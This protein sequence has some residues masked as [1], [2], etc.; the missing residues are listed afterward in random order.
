M[1][2]SL[3][4]INWILLI[5]I[6]TF[7]TCVTVLNSC[8]NN[9]E[10]TK[11]NSVSI[12]TDENVDEINKLRPIFIGKDDAPVEIKIYSSLTCPHCAN[13][14]I[15][16]LPLIEEKYVKTGKVKI[17]FIDFPLDLA[18][19][20]ASKILHCVKKN[21]QIST[22]DLIYE[23]QNQWSVS[24]DIDEVNKKLKEIITTS[25]INSDQID[26]CFVDE[27]IENQVLN[28]RIEGHKKYSISST[29]TIIIN[30]KKF[31]GPADFEN[32]EKAID[33]II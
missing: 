13:F 29:P 6:C 5:Q 12:K 21:K 9:N 28:A 32:I 24:S 18:A 8:D 25:G 27:N 33:K 7:I 26:E 31:I 11:K 22:M 23:K 14:H 4:S 1:N 15:N 16:V 19:L 17:V 3:F 20:N 2:K 30:E 10:K